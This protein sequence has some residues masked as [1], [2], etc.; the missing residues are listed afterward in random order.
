MAFGQVKSG[1]S[2][3]VAASA[4]MTIQPPSGEEWVVFSIYREANATI[5]FYNGT[6]AVAFKV[7]TGAGETKGPFHLTATNYLRVQNNDAAAKDL[8][9]SGVQIR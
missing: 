3:A 1:I 2:A 7:E 8:G 6:T 4:Y 5:E 9:Y